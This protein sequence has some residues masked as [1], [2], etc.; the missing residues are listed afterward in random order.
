MTA[1]DTATMRNMS[2]MMEEL[3]MEEMVV[4]DGQ[5]MDRLSDIRRSV[6]PVKEGMNIPGRVLGFG[7]LNA[8]RRAK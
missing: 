6:S 4:Y 1:M 7:R 2:E 8:I 3:E 5:I